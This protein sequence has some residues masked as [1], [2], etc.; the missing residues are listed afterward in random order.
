MAA[1]HTLFRHVDL[2]LARISTNPGGL[3]VPEFLSAGTEDAAG[4]G[5]AW[6]AR[7]W[8]RVEIRVAL[9]IASP[10]LAEQIDQLAAGDDGDPRQVRRV[11]AATSSYLLR[12]RRRATPFGL[13]AGVAAAS[14]GTSAS[15]RLDPECRVSAR[16]DARWF[17]EIITGLQRRHDLLP[18]LTVVTNNAAFRRGTRVVT[19]A[20]PDE[21]QPQ[22]GAALDT[23]IRHTR[24]VAAALDGAA[25]PVRTA[26]LAERIGA[27]F[28]ARA[29]RQSLG[30][31]RN[32]S[33]AAP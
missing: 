19:P 20:R 4:T 5:R 32:W 16:A 27:E 3:D 8:Q 22:R 21:T 17:G 2:V 1:K 29:P 9:R 11:L 10:A 14:I 24:A 31:S 7:L 12:W 6:L 30:C 15:A 23:S 33:R 18:R 25:S 26:E 28:P 13:F